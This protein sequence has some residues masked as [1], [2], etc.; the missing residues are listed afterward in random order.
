MRRTDEPK[1]IMAVCMVNYCGH[2]PPYDGP[3]P[4]VS[5]AAAPQRSPAMGTKLPSQPKSGLFR[6]KRPKTP[7]RTPNLMPLPALRQYLGLDTSFCQCWRSHGERPRKGPAVASCLQLK[8]SPSPPTPHSAVGDGK[9]NRHR[10]KQLPGAVAAEMSQLPGNWG[11]L[12]S[13]LCH[14][15]CTRVDYGKHTKCSR[16]CAQADD[17]CCGVDNSGGR[18][19]EV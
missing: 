19:R 10:L 12:S 18:V 5:L 6:A 3:W 7:L 13:P 9:C 15:Y 17:G 14:C 16:Y 4:S 2:A 1:P 8:C 11:G